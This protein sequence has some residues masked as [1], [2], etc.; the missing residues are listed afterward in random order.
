MC[1]SR[2]RRGAPAVACIGY[3]ASNYVDCVYIYDP[4]NNRFIKA[5]AD[6]C[7]V[8]VTTWQDH[9]AEIRLFLQAIA[10]SCFT[11]GLRKFDFY[12]ITRDRVSVVSM[13]NKC[14]TPNS[15]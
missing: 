5:F 13:Q 3:S 15:N 1:G 12:T 6:N 4:F 9:L 10:K 11:L 2:A 8:H 7:A 14:T